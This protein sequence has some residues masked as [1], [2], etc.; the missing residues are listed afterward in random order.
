[1]VP[2]QNSVTLKYLFDKANQ[3]LWDISVQLKPFK[4]RIHRIKSNFARSESFKKVDPCAVERIRKS[5]NEEQEE[6]EEDD[7]EDDVFTFHHS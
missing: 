5:S 6:E 2:I 3:S 4:N 7:E 1:M